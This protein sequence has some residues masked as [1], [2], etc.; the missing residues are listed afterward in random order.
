MR[1]LSRKISYWVE[2]LSR[3]MKKLQNNLTVIGEIK[4]HNLADKVF[5]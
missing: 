4:V 5:Q 1:K 2:A 3:E